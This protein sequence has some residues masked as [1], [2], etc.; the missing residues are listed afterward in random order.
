MLKVHFQDMNG[1]GWMT[2]AF[3]GI[4]FCHPARR[5]M[6]WE[7]TR[8]CHSVDFIVHV[9]SIR[10]GTVAHSGADSPCSQCQIVNRRF[11]ILYSS[12]MAR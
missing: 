10:T 1:N 2:M 5:G 6:T 4:S 8:R 7:F 3:T 9:R 12:N 11:C